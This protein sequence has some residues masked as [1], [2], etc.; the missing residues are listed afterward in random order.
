[1]DQEANQNCPD[2]QLIKRYVEGLAMLNEVEEV[3][4]HLGR[5]P[6]CAARITSARTARE[7]SLKHVN[8][9]L[10]QISADQVQRIKQSAQ[11]SG[12]SFDN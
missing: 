5:H 2:D 3:L 1:M 8:A 4:A 12:F 11:Q 6:D 7:A 10:A 9:M